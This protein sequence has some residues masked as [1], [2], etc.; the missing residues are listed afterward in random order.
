MRAAEKEIEEAAADLEALKKKRR[1]G[2]PD[3][4]SPENADLAAALQQAER[5]LTDT[6]RKFAKARARVEDAMRAAEALGVG[7]A[8][9][10]PE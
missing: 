9:D 2:P 7:P 4:A 10:A 6:Y 1:S 3:A 8:A 5:R